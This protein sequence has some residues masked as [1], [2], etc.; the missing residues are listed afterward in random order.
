MHSIQGNYAVA[1]HY[2]QLTERAKKDQLKDDKELPLKWLWSV[3]EMKLQQSREDKSPRCVEAIVAVLK[4][5][6]TFADSDVVESSPCLSRHHHHLHATA[7]QHLANL[8]VDR[9]TGTTS[10]Y[11]HTGPVVCPQMHILHV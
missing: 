8:V 4:Q 6:S 7:L 9:A 3:T 1:K 2:L 10:L 5:F 11:M